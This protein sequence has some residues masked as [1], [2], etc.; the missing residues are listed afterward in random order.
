[1][2]IHLCGGRL[3]RS[4]FDLIPKWTDFHFKLSDNADV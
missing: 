4:V 2:D 3:T 1:V